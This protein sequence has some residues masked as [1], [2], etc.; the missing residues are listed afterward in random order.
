[1]NDSN[2]GNVMAIDVTGAQYSVDQGDV[3]TSG[4]GGLPASPNF[5]FDSATVH[6]GQRVEVESSSTMSGTSLIADKVKLRQQGLTG[7]V[8][9]LSAPTSAGPVQFTLTVASDSAFAMLSGQTT[10]TVFWQPGTEL[11][12]V[13]SVKN[14]DTVRVRGLVFFTGTTFNM[15]AKRIGQ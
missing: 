3:D 1:M 5:P 9:A 15:I 14:G 11:H 6:A 13:A 7:T 12:N 8:S 10:V 2:V 4:I